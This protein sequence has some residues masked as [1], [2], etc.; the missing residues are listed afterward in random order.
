MVFWVIKPSIPWTFQNF[1]TWFGVKPNLIPFTFHPIKIDE[2]LKLEPMLME[3]YYYGG[4][5]GIQTW[6]KQ[7]F[8][9]LF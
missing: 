8:E 4:K 9:L 2:F 3:W 7:N 6:F 5:R 1:G